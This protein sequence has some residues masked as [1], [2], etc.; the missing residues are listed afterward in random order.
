MFSTISK[1]NANKES[2]TQYCHLRLH[3]KDIEGDNI[4][5]RTFYHI[6]ISEI[7]PSMCLFIHLMCFICID[8]LLLWCPL[9]NVS[10]WFMV[11][12]RRYVDV[13]KPIMF[14]DL[15]TS[16]IMKEIS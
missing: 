13:S 7:D 10:E 11:I 9:Q 14:D 3:G 6:P 4:N 1:P 12:L 8:T 5:P 16:K 15:S 2:K